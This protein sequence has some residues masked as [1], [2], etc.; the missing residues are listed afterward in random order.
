MSYQPL[1]NITLSSSAS[2]VTFS[3]IPT[4]FRDLVLVTKDLAVGGNGSVRIRF[5]GDTTDGN[6]SRVQMFGATTSRG[7]GS[8][9]GHFFYDSYETQGQPTLVNINDYSASNKDKT[10]LVRFSGIDSYVVAG[11]HRWAN[12]A[13]I[14]SIAIVPNGFSFASGSTFALYGIRS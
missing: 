14:T 13:A 12:T 5:N 4:T 2:S 7:V 8:T 9:N 10:I 1:S 6:Y 11:A 3:S